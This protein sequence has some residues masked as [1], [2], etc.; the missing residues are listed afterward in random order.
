MVALSVHRSNGSIHSLAFVRGRAENVL[1]VA[2]A[3]DRSTFGVAPVAHLVAVLGISILRD[4]A[5]VV[6]HQESREDVEGRV[7]TSELV[8]LGQLV[9]SDVC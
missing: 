4:E 1:V 2:I 8:K 6:C 5:A 7:G 3:S 9:K